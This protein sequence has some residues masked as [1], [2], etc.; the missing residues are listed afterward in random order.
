MENG[1]MSLRDL[2]NPPVIRINIVYV[3]KMDKNSNF[4]C[5]GMS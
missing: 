1:R 3:I 2:V 5:L 4:I